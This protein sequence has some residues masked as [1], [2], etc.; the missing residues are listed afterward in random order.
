MNITIEEVFEAYYD[1]RK[2]KRYSSG[3]LQY[4]SDMERSLIELYNELNEKHGNPGLRRV[5][6]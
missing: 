6:S 3:S 4:E 2:N 1:C 5:L